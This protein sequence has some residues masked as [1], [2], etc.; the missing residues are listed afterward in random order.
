[1][2]VVSL[3]TGRNEHDFF[4]RVDA[5][6]Q[7]LEALNADIVFLQEVLVVPEEGI[8]T[9]RELSRRLSMHHVHQPQRFKPRALYGRSAPSTSG[10]SVLTR[11]PVRSIKAIRLPSV[12]EDGERLSQVVEL[13]SDVG[14]LLL[15]NVHLSFMTGDDA[16]RLR[17]EQM[18][19]TID[20]AEAEGPARTAIIGGDF[21]TAPGDMAF[22]WMSENGRFDFGPGPLTALPPTYLGGLVT[23]SRALAQAIDHIA[24]YHP[25]G[26]PVLKVS[27]RFLAL[28]EPN[29]KTGI[30]ASDHAAVVADLV[31][32]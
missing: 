9:S 31:A 16:E 2:R 7:G 28:T 19:L 20:E 13:E 12:P 26:A 23:T 15:V 14:P 32:M 29:L 1:M 18:R 3:N 30:M 6:A 25:D 17:L 8:D 5:I 11:H 27:R 4:G 24:V 22:D 10:L 21:N